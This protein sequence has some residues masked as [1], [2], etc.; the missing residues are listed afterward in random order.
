MR[1]SANLNLLW[2]NRDVYERVSAAAAAGFRHVELLFPQDLDL[3]R[4]ETSLARS[5]ARMV[6]FD[7]TA[8]DWSAGERGL[9]TLP[10]REA[11]FDASIQ[12]A[13]ELAARFG[14]RLVNVLAGIPLPDA[15]TRVVR[16]TALRNLRAAADRAAPAGVTLLV[17]SLNT[18]EVPG[19]WAGTVDVAAALVREVGRGNVRLQLDQYHVGRMGGDPLRA[20]DEHFDI[21]GHVQIAD[22]PGRH[23]P[24]TGS[25]PIGEFLEALEAR[26]YAGFV[27]LEYRPL[28]DTDAGLAWL[29]RLTS[30][31]RR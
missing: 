3:A 19:Y 30:T 22:V 12:T 17:E 6:L 27:G 16:E 15:D 29:S 4:L 26:G 1:W 2:P 8:G 21:L 25:Q 11:E 28:G 14:T 9:T 24:G 13:L 23:E 31:R 7:A 10:G 5:G 20:L 18:A